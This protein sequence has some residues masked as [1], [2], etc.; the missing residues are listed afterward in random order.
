ML[1]SGSSLALS[2]NEVRGYARHKPPSGRAAVCDFSGHQRC[3]GGTLFS[4][5]REDDE[6]TG[7]ALIMILGLGVVFA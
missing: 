1:V 4:R 3:F 5:G 7:H 2:F 6:G